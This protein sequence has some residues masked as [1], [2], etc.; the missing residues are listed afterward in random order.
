[1][2]TKRLWLGIAAS[3]AVIGV[4]AGVTLAA[5]TLLGVT[6]EESEPK[7]AE[8]TQTNTEDAS[9]PAPAHDQQA[10]YPGFSFCV[11]AIGVDAAVEAVGK[12]NIETALLE[13]VQHP[14][15]NIR[16]ERASVPPLVE[17]GCP[18]DPLIA[19]P[20][21]NWD[22]PNFYA[23]GDIHQYNVV[24]P[25]FY[26]TFIFIMPSEQISQLIGDAHIPHAPQ[27]YRW[28]GDLAI[29]ETNAMFISPQQLE[30]A[31]FLVRQL[32]IAVGLEPP[33]PESQFPDRSHR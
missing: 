27:E 21:V 9:G 12:A 31:S 7:P 16:Q 18:S 1:M 2:R 5:T 4:V 26:W 28:D 33:F 30:D 10:R 23:R 6:F 15:W 14:Y 17:I 32:L 25:S 11:E 3:L 13:V 29:M 22:G 8:G 19:R 20:G 24:Q